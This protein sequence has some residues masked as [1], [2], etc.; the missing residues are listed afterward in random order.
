MGIAPGDL[1]EAQPDLVQRLV[2]R[3]LRRGAWCS[4]PR[5]RRAVEFEVAID[6]LQRVERLERVLED[7]LHTRHEVQPVRRGTGMSALLLPSNRISPLVGC[8][9]PRIMR[10]ERRLARPGLAD[11]REDL[12]PV[13]DKR[14]IG[15]HDGIDVAAREPAAHDE[16]LGDVGDFE[17][18]GHAHHLLVHQRRDPSE[19]THVGA[20][21]A[22]RAMIQPDRL[23]RRHLGRALVDGE[24]ATRVEAAAGGRF[25][26]VGRS[27]LERRLRRGVADARA[28]RRPDGRCRDAA[29]RRRC[30]RVGPS[31]TSR[32]AYMMPMRSAMLACTLMSWVTKTT[33][34]ADLALHIAD[35][36]QHV[37]LHHHVERGGRFVGDDELG[38][39]HGGQR[40]GHPL[41]HAARQL[42]RIGAT[43]RRRTARD[44]RRCASTRSQNSALGSPI[45]RNAKSSNVVRMRR[46]GLSKLI[47]P[48]MM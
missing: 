5:R 36:R 23:E 12:G 29:A 19:R 26:E 47:E 39:T 46:T 20:A 44:A 2:H 17:Q 30:V 27:P 34:D 40:D 4:P 14:E 43:A 33:D 1:L 37:L 7:R 28:A 45:G 18:R 15:V 35:H 13:G 38:L 25:G 11:D 6:P 48:C 8:S 21:P 3:R 31:S 41:A 32:P 24:R 9:R 42:V 22:R 16:S 10:G